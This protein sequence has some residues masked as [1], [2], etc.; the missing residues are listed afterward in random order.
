MILRLK[1]EVPLL[2]KAK[3]MSNDALVMLKRVWNL[4]SKL[5]RLRLHYTEA[6][7]MLASFVLG[8][9]F[10]TLILHFNFIFLS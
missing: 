4:S 6:S 7:V 9:S 3:P 5:C 1:V 2:L 8:V 10:L